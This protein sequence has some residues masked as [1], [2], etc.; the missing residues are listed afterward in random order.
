MFSC[1]AGNT[2]ACTHCRAA[3]IITVT[4]SPFLEYSEKDAER[5]M[6][7]APPGFKVT[8]GRAARDNPEKLARCTAPNCSKR[9]A[10]SVFS[11]K[12]GDNS[13]VLPDPKPGTQPLPLS[14][15]LCT[16]RPHILK[17][18]RQ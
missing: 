2:A 3:E 4:H 13:T 16:K 8:V 6:R 10:V 7:K 1:V 18:R 15:A 14:N 12:P 9:I 5:K 17:D 11:A